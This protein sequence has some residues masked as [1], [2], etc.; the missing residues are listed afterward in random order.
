MS[1]QRTDTGADAATSTDADPGEGL[2]TSG[3]SADPGGGAGGDAG[4]PQ[5]T[6]DRPS[7]TAADPG[8]TEGESY[9]KQTQANQDADTDL[10]GREPTAS[11]PS[12][13]SGSGSGGSSEAGGGAGNPAGAGPHAGEISAEPSERRREQ[14][15]GSVAEEFG[16]RA[17]TAPDDDIARPSI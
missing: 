2:G 15:P 6:A 13:D 8:D 12:G 16:D 11:G 14:D 5:P 10:S 4:M 3:P 9:L 7:G 17:G 1:E